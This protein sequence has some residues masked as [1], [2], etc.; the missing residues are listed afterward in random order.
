MV[1]PEHVL[2]LMLRASYAQGVIN[3]AGFGPLDYAEFGIYTAEHPIN[4][5]G[6][7]QPIIRVRCHTCRQDIGDLES[8]IGAPAIVRLMD[9]HTHS[10][11][12]SSHAADARSTGDEDHA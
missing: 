10:V 6:L 2:D 5:K 3:A 11:L 8:G 7:T 1:K 4:S 9:S 12:P